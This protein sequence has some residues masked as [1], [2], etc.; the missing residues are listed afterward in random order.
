MENISK[1]NSNLELLRIF[2]MILIITHHYAVHDFERYMS[3]ISF[4][5][6]IIDIL[7]L[8]G[9]IGVCCFILISGYFMIESKFTIKKLWKIIGEV[10]FYSYSILILFTTILQPVNGINFKIIIQSLLPITHSLYWFITCYVVLMII[11]PYINKF[12]HSCA[13][14][15]LKKFII[16]MVFLWTVLA[17]FIKADLGFSNLGWFIVLY[18]ISA[19]I[20]LYFDISNLPINKIKIILLISVFVLILSSVTINKIGEITG[21]IGIVTHSQYFAQLN[22]ILVLIISITM[23]L[24]FLSRKNFNNVIINEMAKC[25]LGVYLIHDN[26]LFRPFL[27]HTLLNTDKYYTS[28]NL[29]F[30]AIISVVLVYVVCTIIDYAR[31]KL[32]EP[33]WLKIYE[34]IEKER[35]NHI[36]SSCS[37]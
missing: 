1:R 2:S 14:E 21:I 37:K 29:I 22:S 13:K 16:L 28:N 32:I 12:I 26:V 17:T 34:Y 6:Y 31:K 30:H 4:N 19:Y 10:S 8:G 20:K 7:S 18:T 9:K 11:S 33:V 24:Y 23:F 3:Y 25:V 36:K 27:W 5:K 35:K 15:E